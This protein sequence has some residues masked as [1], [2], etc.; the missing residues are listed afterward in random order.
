M[1]L[2]GMETVNEELMD[3]GRTATIDE[4]GEEFQVEVQDEYV[5]LVLGWLHDTRF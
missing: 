4:L 3:A 2:S 5:D 1:R